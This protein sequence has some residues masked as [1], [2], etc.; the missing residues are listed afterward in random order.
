[1]MSDIIITGD[2]QRA[3]IKGSFG[4]DGLPLPFVREI[5]LLEC[6]VAGTGFRNLAD[7]ESDLE[8]GDLLTFKRELGN[9]PAF[10]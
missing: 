10:Q 9:K 8:P 3:L 7:I 5:F 4:K 2:V 6:H 1:M